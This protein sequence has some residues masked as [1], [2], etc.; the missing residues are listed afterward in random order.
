MKDMRRMRREAFERLYEA[1]ARELLAFLV[2]RTGDVGLAE[3]I[4]ADTF[5]RVLERGGSFD[6][7]RGSEKTWLYSV[8]LNRLRDHARRTAAEARAL[9]KVASGGGDDAA[10]GMEV[11][12]D[13]DAVLRGLAGL[14]DEEREAVA[15]RYGADLSIKE[16]AKLVRRPTTTVKGRLYHGLQK[17]RDELG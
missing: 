14:S 1:H 3:D 12:E 6:P 2:Y 8:A 7:R 10:P 4:H 11:V 17:L 15:L 9:E 16:I 5:E 13:R